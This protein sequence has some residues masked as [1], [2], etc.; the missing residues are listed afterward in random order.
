M[1]EID[2][3]ALSDA[4]EQKRQIIYRL[5]EVSHLMLE[6]RAVYATLVGVTPPQFSILTAISEAPGMP[7]GEVAARLNVSGPFVT[8]EV[9]KL[10]RQGL[11]VKRPGQHDKR[12]SE[13]FLTEQGQTSL[14]RADVERSLAND[15]IFKAFSDA[16]LTAL[17]RQ[18]HVLF[19]GLG[20]A[21]HNLS[22]PGLPR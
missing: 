7:I 15:L 19:Q 4:E 12:R 18:L 21:V 20:N 8:S 14:Q 11:V 17:N 22:R 13:L 3:A 6:T 5:L 1:P 10:S 16:E 2:S 9:Q